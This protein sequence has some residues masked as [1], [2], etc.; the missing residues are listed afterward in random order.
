M[1]AFMFSLMRLA[2]IAGAQNSI[3][4]NYGRVA[5]NLPSAAQVVRLLQSRSVKHVR[6]YDTDATV[7]NAF[8]NSG[9]DVGVTIPNNE[10]AGLANSAAAADQWVANNIIRFGSTNFA[11]IAVGNEVLDDQ[12]F[13]RS[14]LV[15]A[16]RNVQQSLQNRGRSSIKVSTP[17]SM[18]NL[19]AS[20]GFPPSSGTFRPEVTDLLRSILA[21]LSQT[22][23]VFMI[24][25]YPYFSYRDNRGVDI[26]LDYA[27]GNPSAAPVTD[28]GNGLVYHNIFDA[29]LDTVLA[30]MTRVGYGNVPFLITES[31]WPSG[32]GSEFGASVQNA[33]NYNTN[34]VRHVLGSSGTP[35]RPGSGRIPTFIFAL[36]NENRKGGNPVEQNFGLYY[37]NQT[38][39]YNVPL[40]VSSQFCLCIDKHGSTVESTERVAAF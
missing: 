20:P 10:V 28:S 22:N 15:P 24:N 2:T 21:F 5:D 36:F 34:L 26:K 6:I 7:L 16:M 8:G 23:S 31:G 35:R 37:P 12:S 14:K 30:A 3:G 39:V 40:T 11:T 29:M 1:V 32:P 4:V 13:D 19:L 27:L 38:P 18:N 9:I 17:L 33:Q 25:V